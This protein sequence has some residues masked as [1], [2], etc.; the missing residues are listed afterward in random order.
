M[1]TAEKLGSDEFV[2]LETTKHEYDVARLHI[3]RKGISLSEQIDM[4]NAVFKRHDLVLAPEMQKDNVDFE[5]SFRD[6]FPARYHFIFV[7]KSTF[8]NADKKYFGSDDFV[9]AIQRVAAT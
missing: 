5:L 6:E 3:H 7:Q 4:L 2:V 8:V 9:N 1:N